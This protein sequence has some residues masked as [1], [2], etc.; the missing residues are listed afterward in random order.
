MG[1]WHTV[2]E[3]REHVML[4]YDSRNW[5]SIVRGGSMETGR[6][7][8]RGTERG[9]CLLWPGEERI[10]PRRANGHISGR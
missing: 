3:V 8:V 6:C 9:I 7:E 2:G 1:N 10:A 4:H 5:H